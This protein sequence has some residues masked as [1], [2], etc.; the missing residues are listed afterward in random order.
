MNKYKAVKINGKKMD[1]HRYIMEQHLG[2]KLSSDE[3]VHHKNGDP[4]D[5]RIENLEIL[6]RSVHSRNHRLGQHLTD[7]TKER[8]RESNYEKLVCHIR[9]TKFS[10]EQIREIRHLRAEGV[11]VKK[12]A[13]RYSSTPRYVRK[14]IKREI[15]AWVAD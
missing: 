13:E 6:M 5:N 8:L 10:E 7:E 1:E 15:Y 11:S 14:I 3:V 2:R 12:I 9:S 4:S